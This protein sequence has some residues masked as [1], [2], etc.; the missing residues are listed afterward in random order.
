MLIHRSTFKHILISAAP[1]C[2]FW[3]KQHEHF[4]YNS[5]ELH[6]LCQTHNKD[7]V[8]CLG[9]H[10]PW[11]LWAQ[12][13]EET[14]NQRKLQMKH[15]PFWLLAQQPL[16]GVSGQLWFLREDKE[17]EGIFPKA[18]LLSKHTKKLCRLK[19]RQAAKPSLLLLPV[20][21]L[22]SPH[23]NITYQYFLWKRI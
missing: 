22:N 7:D 2:T 8:F 10:R 16:A 9:T 3:A 13:R 1:L 15:L 23:L 5:F 18:Q 14:P 19:R 21:N 12:G 6:L 17:Q 20:K 11:A 4:V